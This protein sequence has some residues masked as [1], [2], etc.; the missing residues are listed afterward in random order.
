MERRGVVLRSYT[1]T[2][3]KALTRMDTEEPSISWYTDGNREKSLIIVE[4]I[5]SAVRASLYTNSV[6]LLGTH[7]AQKYMYEITNHADNVIWILDND[8][9]STALKHVKEHR[10]L[11]K[12]SKVHIPTKDLKN[13]SEPE[14][15]S[16]MERLVHKNNNNGAT[17]NDGRSQL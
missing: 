14:L 13:M 17:N 7:T 11:F 6:A 1:G 8:A 3:P 2:K 16:L 4:D 15:S 10:L 5:P 9:S 12:T